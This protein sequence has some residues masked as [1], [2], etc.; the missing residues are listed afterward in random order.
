MD[1]IDDS[2][3][4]SH[5]KSDSGRKASKKKLKED[6]GKT[7]QVSQDFYLNKSFVLVRAN[8]LITIAH[9]ILLIIIIVTRFSE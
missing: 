8:L 7:V 5:N 3:K 4:K 1:G 6:A 9:F 2:K